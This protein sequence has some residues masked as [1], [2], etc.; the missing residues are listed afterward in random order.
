M[1]QINISIEDIFNSYPERTA[2]TEHLT[3]KEVEDIQEIF[4]SRLQSLLKEVANEYLED[5]KNLVQR[6]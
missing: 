2:E 4:N 1:K 3:F 6:K 5:C